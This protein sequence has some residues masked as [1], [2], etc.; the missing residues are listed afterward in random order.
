MMC[1]KGLHQIVGD[2]IMRIGRT[3]CC[4]A[5]YIERYKENNEKKRIA[6]NRP[7][8]RGVRCRNGHDLTKPENIY[9]TPAGFRSCRQCLAMAKSRYLA[10]RKA[11]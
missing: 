4:K 11:S 8:Q 1:K 5:C 10:K 2:N 9:L 6:A 3:S 7:S